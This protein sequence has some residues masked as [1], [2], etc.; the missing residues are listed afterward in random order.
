MWSRIKSIFGK[1]V[2]G[3]AREAGYIASDRVWE[4]RDPARIYVAIIMESGQG[5]TP[6]MGGDS[7]YLQ[8]SAGQELS[9]NRLDNAQI[10]CTSE[11]GMMRNNTPGHHEEGG[12]TPLAISFLKNR[13]VLASCSWDELAVMKERLYDIDNIREVHQDKAV[14]AEALKATWG[15]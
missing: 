2:D 14:M 1:S 8:L 12:K 13:R 9:F 11:I 10:F 3:A 5:F 4:N 15:S 6:T 7:D